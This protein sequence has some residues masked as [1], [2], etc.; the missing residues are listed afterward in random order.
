MKLDKE[1]YPDDKTSVDFAHCGN[2]D[3]HSN[4]ES[5]DAHVKMDGEV[6]KEPIQNK[7]DLSVNKDR[8]SNS[9]VLQVVSFEHEK[10]QI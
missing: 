1:N 5:I 9:I 4:L 7:L 10:R 2:L 6:K 3:D 8:I